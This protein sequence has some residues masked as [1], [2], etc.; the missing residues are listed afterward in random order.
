MDILDVLNGKK[1]YIGAVGFALV[2]I[3]YVLTGDMQAA[4]T[5]ASMAI[6]LAGIRHAIEKNSTSTE[7]K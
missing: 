7:K 5:A 1:T 2:A 6:A 4:G 3:W